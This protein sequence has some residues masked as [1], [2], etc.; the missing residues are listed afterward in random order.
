VRIVGGELGGR[1][2][3]APRGAATRP[4]ADRVKEAMF[5]ILGRPPPGA[6]ALDLYAGSGALGLEALSRGCADAVFVEQ[7][8]PALAAL[9]ANIE[10]LE[11][12]A[13]ARVLEADAVRA[14]ERLA[15]GGERF[16]WIFVDPPYAGGQMER[17]LGA[18]SRVCRHDGTVVAE[19]ACR[20]APSPAASLL[21][22]DK[23]R[24]GDTCVSFYGLEAA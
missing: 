9:W 14:I 2:L 18:V 12:G 11:V 20:H 6:R 24:Y 13:R 8:R 22:R 23:R 3:H 21:P 17:A 10:S 19:H 15:R 1:P 5:N 7:A 16:D 4:T